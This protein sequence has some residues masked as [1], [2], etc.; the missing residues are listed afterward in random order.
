MMAEKLW[1]VKPKLFSK[2]I[3][4][5]FYFGKISNL[6]HTDCIRN[7]LRTYALTSSIS[8]PGITHHWINSQRR[9]IELECIVLIELR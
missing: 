2:T 8:R 4:L 7:R 6:N 1:P 3:G 9:G 5:H